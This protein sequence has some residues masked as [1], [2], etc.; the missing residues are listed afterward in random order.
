MDEYL[1]NLLTIKERMLDFP[2]DA[3]G[4]IV[5]QPNLDIRSLCKSDKRL[6]ELRKGNKVIGAKDYMLVF[7][8]TCFLPFVRPTIPQL[9]DYEIQSARHNQSKIVKSLMEASDEQDFPLDHDFMTEC[10]QTVKQLYQE[11]ESLRFNGKSMYLKMH[12]EKLSKRSKKEEAF[13]QSLF[14]AS[15]NTAGN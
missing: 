6:L 3:D 12:M 2:V 14:E 7:F 1:Q 8:I 13:M 15:K 5:E 11:K 9:K 4:N 10:K